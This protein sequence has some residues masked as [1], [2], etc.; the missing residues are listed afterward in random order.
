VCP[1]RGQEEIRQ[2]SIDALTDHQRAVYDV[3]E[4]FEEIAP[5][6]L[7]QEYRN[8]VENPKS[9]RTVRNYLKKMIRYNLVSAEG[10]IQD[11]VYRCVNSSS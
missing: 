6:D 4:E 8:R 10:S 11:R 3:I 9:D 7:Y 2:K 1:P 5:G